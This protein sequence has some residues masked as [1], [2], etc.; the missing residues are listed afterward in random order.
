MEL[1]ERGN[2]PRL[3]TQVDRIWIEKMKLKL[4]EVFGK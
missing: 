3:N 2:E 1:W 4:N